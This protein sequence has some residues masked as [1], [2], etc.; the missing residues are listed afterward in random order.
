MAAK[1][2]KQWTLQSDATVTQ[3]EAWR[4]NLMYTLSLDPGCAPFIKKDVVWKKAS[5]A[6]P[7]RGFADDGETVDRASRKTAEQKVC[8]LDMM[9]GQIANFVPIINRTTITKQCVSLKAVWQVIR[10]HLGCQQSGA[11]ILDLADISLEPNERPE[12]LYQRILAFVDDT[13][14]KADSG[15]KHFGEAIEE[16]EEM[17]PA[18]DNMIVLTWLKLLHKDLPSFVKHKYC[19]ELRSQTLASLKPEISLA[20]DS[21]LNQL[22]SDQDA[23]AFR[24]AVENRSFKWSER[25]SN[26]KSFP[27]DNHHETKQKEC[28]LCKQA[29]RTYIGHQL[30]K[31]KFLPE[32]ERRYI[33][34]SKARY[35]TPEDI[36]EPEDGDESD[37]SEP[38]YMCNSVK[39]STTVRRIPV[40]ISPYIDVFY[41]HVPLRITLDSGATGNFISFDAAKRINVLIRKHTQSANQADGHSQ[42]K[43][44][45]E[46]SLKISY[47]SHTLTLEALVAENLDDD[48]LAGTPFMELNDVWTRPSKSLIGIGESTYRYTKKDNV[49]LSSQ[50]IHVGR[51]SDAVTVWPGDFLEIDVPPEFPDAEYA[52]EPRIDCHL[53]SK[54]KYEQVWPLPQIVKSVENKLRIPN[55]SHEPKIL[56]KY[57]QF[58]NVRSV[59]TVSNSIPPN[60]CHRNK[61]ILEDKYPHIKISND[62]NNITPSVYKDKFEC[63]N[64][65]FSHVFSSKIPGYNGASGHV[66]AV[67]NMGPVMPPQRKGRLPLYN[68]DK[69]DI[70]QSKFDELEELGVLKKPEDVKINVEY[71]SPSFLVNKPRG[72]H[73]LVT[74]FGDVARYSKP[75]PSLMPDINSTLRSIARWKHIITTDLTKAFFQIPLD[76]A[77]MKFCGVSTPFKGTRVYVRSA[78]GMPGSETCLEEVLCRVLGDQ[79]QDGKVIKLADNLYCG[80]NDLE[81]LYHNWEEVLMCLSK[82]ALCLSPSQTIIN[83]KTVNILGW[84]WT[85][86]VLS[87][88]PHAVTSLM[89]CQKP[90]TVKQMRSFVGAYKVLARVIPKCAIIIATL[91]DMT[92]GKPSAEKLVWNDELIRCYEAAQKALATATPIILPRASDQLWI[93]CDA[94]NAKPGISSTLYITRSNSKKPRIAG[95]FSA[96][97]KGNQIG[98]LPCEREALCI[99]SSISHFQPFITQSHNLTSVLTD[100]DPCVKA[101]GKMAR[102]EF[103]TSPRV[104]TFLSICSRFQIS[105]RH[106]S[107]V[108][109]ALSDHGSRN[110]PECLDNNCQICSFIE[111]TE[112]SVVRG[113][114]VQDILSGDKKI[115][116]TSRVA[117]MATQLDCNDLRRT[118]AHLKQGTRPSKKMTK[119]KDVKRYLN[120]ITIANDGLLVVR[121]DDPMSPVRERIVIPRSAIDGLIT[122]L[123]IKLDHPT[124][125]QMKLL[126]HRYFFALDLDKVIK[127]VTESCHTCGSLASFPDTRI[128]QSSS[129][130]P[131]GVGTQFA[132]DIIRREKQLIFALREYVTSYTWS[133]IIKNEQHNTLREAILQLCLPIRPMDG[134][135]TIIRVDA[136]PGFQSLEGDPT[137]K[138]N[139]ISLEIGRKK[140]PNK[141]PVAERAVSELEIELLKQDPTGGPIS[142]ILLVSATSRLNSRI[143]SRGLSSRE[144]LYQ[145]DQFTNMQIPL[146][147]RELIEKQQIIAEKNHAHSEKS[148]APNRPYRSEDNI[149]IGDLVYLYTD[150]NKNRARDRYLVTSIDGPWLNI[151]K[152]V[153]SQ[154]RSSSY[155]V[156]KSEC[157]KVHSQMFS[158][159][160]PILTEEE[161]D[162]HFEIESTPTTHITDIPI[163]SEPQ[164]LPDPPQIPEEIVPAN[165]HSPPDIVEDI[166]APDIHVETVDNVPSNSTTVQSDSNVEH[167]PSNCNSRP[168]RDCKLPVRFR[169]GTY[170]LY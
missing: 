70:L 65:E 146:T 7:N 67:V 69:L 94:A 15:L 89:T 140:N 13:L 37:Y 128:Q 147:D 32:S 133:C 159:P 155:R 106:I 126:A 142:N 119:I 115:P 98:W 77:S 46:V 48:V 78:M 9:L 163:H 10:Q 123:H 125:H 153:G 52:V 129:D 73:R 167:S 104:S 84:V 90:Q 134:P 139:Q 20:L 79:I 152:F 54:C 72:G 158:L 36:E 35:A 58:C 62:P 41:F 34:S 151:R 143:R 45:G 82:N 44:V 166:D 43:I 23:K 38:G 5:K 110:P 8:A 124:Y 132:C 145:R 108:D 42:L 50:R 130:P 144:M 86:G 88:S 71:I 102:G 53:N 87:V 57:E 107:G 22:R 168:K 51:S 116:Y 149:E 137:L 11:R 18:L 47:K 55:L 49:P 91:D 157:Y 101:R 95:F 6:D 31:C 105:V 76:H 156:K 165:A 122:S 14:L 131:A 111:M 25:S 148:K 2:P 96:K 121:N 63:I 113:I 75:Q 135:D 81:E 64:K 61:S 40:S 39:P 19:T 99:G 109:N 141:N 136:A 164:A 27:K 29:G 33:K 100:S 26:R 21:L 60:T 160:A 92:N 1:A 150:K 118:H 74:D 154:F 161:S 4:Q 97:L 17:T 56:H 66:K 112:N 3:Y 138:Q 80:G 114:T 12:D 83:P 162:S 93:V 103:S 120:N 68:K 30:S 16:D 24:M 169:D 127:Q 117:W 59:S 170:V 85:E 28:E